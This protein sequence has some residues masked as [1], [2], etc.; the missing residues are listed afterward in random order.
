MTIDQQPVDLTKTYRSVVSLTWKI[1]KKLVPIKVNPRTE[2]NQFML[3]S[4]VHPAKK[5]PAGKRTDPIIIGGRPAL[6]RF[7]VSIAKFV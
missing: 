5:N 4:E 1:N 3:G 7:D 2:G 6:Y